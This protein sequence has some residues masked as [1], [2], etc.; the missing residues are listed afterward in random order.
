MPTWKL[1]PAGGVADVLTGGGEEVRAAGCD[2]V[3]ASCFHD[4][5]GVDWARRLVVG[6][7]RVRRN[8]KSPAN[9]VRKIFLGHN[10][11][12]VYGRD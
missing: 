9:L 5:V 10:L 1:L 8:R 2:H 3:S 11:T 7:K 6:G 4:G 12:C